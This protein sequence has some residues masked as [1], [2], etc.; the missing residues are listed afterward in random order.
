MLLGRSTLRRRDQPTTTSFLSYDDHRTE[1]HRLFSSSE[2]SVSSAGHL[3]DRHIEPPP[4]IYYDVIRFVHVRPES[5][6]W[7]R[8]N[9]STMPRKIC[10]L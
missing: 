3:S 8:V 7:R 1:R 5:V 6:A 10:E 2:L 4:S 9:F